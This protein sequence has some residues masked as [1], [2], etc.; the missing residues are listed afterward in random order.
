M[1]MSDEAELSEP[2]M[3]CPGPRAHTGGAGPAHL[4]RNAPAPSFLILCG[5]SA[6]RGGMSSA[7]VASESTLVPASSVKTP[8]AF[9]G[10]PWSNLMLRCMYFLDSFVGEPLLE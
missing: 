4:T 5:D 1:A 9:L 10:S 8:L 6:V 3:R 2:S 7:L